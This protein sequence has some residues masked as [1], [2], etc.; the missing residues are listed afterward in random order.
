MNE[1]PVFEGGNVVRGVLSMPT[2]GDRGSKGSC[3]APSGVFSTTIGVR[4]MSIEGDLGSMVN[5][6]F[7]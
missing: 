1:I 6:L 5:T 3:K 7:P 4:V 2:V